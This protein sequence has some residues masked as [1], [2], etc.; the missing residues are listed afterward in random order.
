MEKQ[1]IKYKN[2]NFLIRKDSSDIKNIKEIFWRNIYIKPKLWFLIKKWE[3]W[4]DFWW[5]IWVFNIYA[6]FK[7]A[8]VISFEPFIDSYNLACENIFLN[9]LKVNVNN[10]WIT[11][12]VD[13]KVDMYIHINNNFWRNSI[14]KIWKSKKQKI[15]I[16]I[17]NYKKFIKNWDCVKMDIEWEEIEI[18]EDFIKS[19]L[20]LKKLVFE[21]SFDVD[22]DLNRYRKIIQWLKLKF[23]NINANNYIW[24]NKCDWFPAYVNVFC[25]ND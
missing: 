16:E 15:Q 20:K 3:N 25:W 17:K 18:L 9:W 10:F 13:K 6:Q 4:L 2:I 5:Y 19:D 21:Y 24:K 12:W 22:D 8:N 14:H 7:W 23:Q 1:L 11:A